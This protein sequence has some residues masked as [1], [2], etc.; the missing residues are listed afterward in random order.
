MA[1]V[2]SRAARVQFYDLQLHPIY[3]DEWK[4]SQYEFPSVF[5]FSPGR[6]RCGNEINELMLS[7]R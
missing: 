2:L 6:P 5:D 4:R 3:C 7:V 1:N